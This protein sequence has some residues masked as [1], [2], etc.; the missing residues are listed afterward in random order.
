MLFAV[1]RD[2]LDIIPHLARRIVLT[3]GR[4]ERGLLLGDGILVILGVALLK[5]ADLRVLGI[6]SVVE[7]F[8]PLLTEPEAL[9]ECEA[10]RMGS[11][12]IAR[13]WILTASAETEASG[14]TEE[15]QYSHRAEL[16]NGSGAPQLGQFAIFLL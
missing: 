4:L 7:A 5:L 10:N 6:E 16:D 14:S 12:S 8:Q 2:D 9:G 15:P 3:T 11:T 13:S 1:S